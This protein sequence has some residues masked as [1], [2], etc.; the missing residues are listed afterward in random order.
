[1]IDSL[2]SEV[3]FTLVNRNRTG[4]T[5]TEAGERLLPAIRDIARCSQR[6]DQLAA[7]VR[8]I[9]TGE[10]IIATY[11]SIAASWMP[12]II[13][14]FE[15]DYP[16]VHISMRE[17]GN[18]AMTA[19]VR[20]GQVDCAFCSRREGS[21]DWVPLRDDPLVAWLPA[22]HPLASKEAVP[23]AALDGLPFIMPLPGSDTDVERLLEHENLRPDVRFTANDGFTAGDVKFLSQIDK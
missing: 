20:S 9:V 11:Y 10:I 2:E 15:A 5:T 21:E 8:G 13:A 1:M 23:L 6:L 14:A 12:R 22:N 16:G 19:W 17:A 7:E 18:S 4:I 3:G